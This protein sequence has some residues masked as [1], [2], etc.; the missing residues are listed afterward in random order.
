MKRHLISADS[1][2]KLKKRSGKTNLYMTS[3]KGGGFNI[4]DKWN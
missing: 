1:C 4:Y 2:Q 3:T